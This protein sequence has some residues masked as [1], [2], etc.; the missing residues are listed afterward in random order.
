MKKLLVLPVL[1][2]ITAC[3]FNDLMDNDT[4]KVVKS[5]LSQKSRYTINGCYDEIVEYKFDESRY[6]KIFYKDDSFTEVEKEINGDVEYVDALNITL[7]E[8][9][10]ILDCGVKYI[11]NDAIELYCKNRDEES[12]YHVKRTLYPDKEDAI[13]H[14]DEDC[15]W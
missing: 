3:S 5:E 7:Y 9:S 4:S 15:N 13:E 1:F 14:S 10:L 11:D 6:K 8:N 12:S 2:L